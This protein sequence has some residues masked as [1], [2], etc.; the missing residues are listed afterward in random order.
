V[1]DKLFWFASVEYRDQDGGVLVG[2]RNLATRTIDKSFAPAPLKDTMASGRLDWVPSAADRVTFRYAFQHAADTGASTLNRAIGSASYRQEGTNEGHSGL[3]SWTHSLSS[4]STNSLLFAVSDFDNS[5]MP[6]TPGTQF[7]FPSIVDGASFRVPQAT[8][9]RRYQLNDTV[10]FLLGSHSLKVGAEYQKVSANF[11]LGVFRQGRIEFVQDFPEFDLNGDGRVDDNDLLF[12]VTL[13]SNKPDQDLNLNNQD[14]THFAGFV[15]DDW[16]IHPQFTINAGLRY[17]FD[18][19]VKNVSGYDQVNPIVKPFYV[20]DRKRDGNNFGPRVGFNWA[21]KDGRTSVHGGY[22][23][24]YD[25]VTLEI[26]SL[27]RGLDG[28]SLVVEVRA[29][30]VFFL[31]PQGPAPGAPSLQDPFTGFILPGAGASGIDI[32]DNR[33]QNPTVQQFNFGAQR[34]FGKDFVVKADYVHNLGTHFIIGRPLGTVFNPVV[35]G[36]DTVVNLESS[37][38]THYDGLLVSTEKRFSQGS[39][40]RVAYTFSKALNYANDDQ[41]PFSYGPVDPNNLRLEYGPTPND[42]RH[43]VNVSGTFV[44]PA[45]FRLSPLF[46]FATGV[47]MDIQMPDGSSRVP[48]FQ[49]NA[50][51]RQFKTGAQLNAFLQNLNASGGINGT[52]LPLVNDDARFSDNFQSLDVRLSKSFHLGKTSSIE[53]IAEAFN[54]YNA[55]NILGVSTSNYS[56]FSNVLVRDSSDPTSAG[57]LRSSSFGKPITTAGGVFGSGG[58]RAFQFGAR[59]AF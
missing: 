3:A 37:V 43:R 44:L 6:V 11:G 16:R 53:V 45:G 23:I 24:Y 22:G 42:Q 12:A 9:Q 51:G 2:T 50:G 46:T 38:N 28:R 15:Q 58:P 8:T 40:V 17:E 27:E 14:N 21:S 18:T 20:G 30:N 29:G 19:D 59:I 54:L 35:G 7:T 39:Q 41:I 5:T 52:L 32:I 56:G 57:Y 13:R 36:P 49:R 26:V 33:Q 10:S 25:R 1:K 31:G 34:Q 48:A 4:S 47:P 55:T